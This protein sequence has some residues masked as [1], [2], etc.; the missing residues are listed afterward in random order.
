MLRCPPL[1]RRLSAN[2]TCIQTARYQSSQTMA[3]YR[4]ST[5][6]NKEDVLLDVCYNRPS[7]LLHLDH[8]IICAKSEKELNATLKGMWE[9]RNPDYTKTVSRV[10]DAFNKVKKE[11]ALSPQALQTEVE[12]P[13]TQTREKRR[14]LVRLLD[15]FG[16]DI[17]NH[18]MGM[19]TSQRATVL[20]K[21]YPTIPAKHRPDLHAFR[22]AR[23]GA[24]KFPFSNQDVLRHGN[25]NQEDL[26]SDAIM[27]D[28]VRSRSRNAAHKFT[29]SYAR[30]SAFGYFVQLQPFSSLD[31]GLSVS[32][33]LWDLWSD[34]KIGCQKPR[35]H[36]GSWSWAGCP[37]M[38]LWRVGL[39][40]KFCL[41]DAAR[42]ISS[43]YQYVHRR[44]QPRANTTF[45][46]VRDLS[47]IALY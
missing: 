7:G 29:H 31:R 32:S 2:V 39:Y 45:Q 36:I 28:F 13:A 16:G 3:P 5:Q 20:Q 26:C 41:W 15:H 47:P 6:V 17:Y 44:N 24:F 22:Q 19:T 10:L 4:I 34:R 21:I 35:S 11:E 30:S 38:P 46:R 42:N 40:N 14:A 18:W 12:T 37:Q 33:R 1:D 23:K 43:I 25:I 9:S 8:T 27:M